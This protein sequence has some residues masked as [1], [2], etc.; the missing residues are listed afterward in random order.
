MKPQKPMPETLR[1]KNFVANLKNRPPYTKEAV[2]LKEIAGG[3]QWRMDAALEGLL[4]KPADRAYVNITN[5]MKQAAMFGRLQTMEKMA[6]AFN[7]AED[8]NRHADGA[9]IAAFQ[10]AVLHGH[11]KVAD[12]L[13]AKCGAHPDYDSGDRTPPAMAWAVREGDLKKIA[14]LAGKGANVSHALVGAVK[15]EKHSKAVID[16][17]IAKGADVNYAAE[18]FW[19]PFL[20]AVKYRNGALAEHLLAKG[21]D[22]SKSGGEVMLHLIESRNNTLLEK[23]IAQGAKPDLDLVQ[24][25][26]YAGNFQAAETMMKTGL[27]IND[28]GGVVLL[29][30]IHAKEQPEAV[31]FCLT[32]GADPKISL[33]TASRPKQSW[34]KSEKD[35][36]V[37]DYLVRLIQQP[38]V[39]A[40]TPAPKPPKFG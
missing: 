2:L 4:A 10:V 14:Y 35:E 16:L 8:G 11:Y 27:D 6:T 39:A 31:M 12:F 17:L 1:Y 5:I 18:G 26:L 13:H 25:A 20:Q 7:F 36:Q 23:V 28:R 37:K 22:P 32:H 30:A 29:T 21:A 34:E 15:N 40:A 19:T 24:R 9:V 33:A 38:P 3:Q